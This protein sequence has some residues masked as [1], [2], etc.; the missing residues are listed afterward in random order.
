MLSNYTHHSGFCQ[1]YLSNLSATK[2]DPIYTTYAAALERSEFTLDEGYHFLFYDSTRGADFVSDKA[3]DICIAFKKKSKYV[4][5]LK[6]LYREPVISHSYPDM[7]KYCYLPFEDIEVDVAF[8]VVSSRM[9][10]MDVTVRNP[11]QQK[12]TLQMIPFLQNNYRTFN[13]VEFL[14]E[15]N[16]IFFT[17][18]EFPDSWTVGHGVPYVDRVQ[19]ILL[20]SQS[21]ARMASY[22]SYEWGGVEIPHQVDLQKKSV[23]QVW[24]RVTHSDGNRCGHRPPKTKLTTILNGDRSRILTET[25]PGWGSGNQNI[26]GNGWYGIELGNF[27]GLGKEDRYEI[28]FVCQETGERGVISGAVAEADTNDNIRKDL[29]LA[30]SR[31]LPSST[32]LKRDIWGSGREIRLYWQ[33]AG[34]EVTYNVYRRDYRQEGTY[35]LLA[36]N[37]SKN[38][39]TDK[40]ISGDKIY[41]YVV[42]AVDAEGTMSMFSGEVN[43]IAGSDFLTGVKY[44]GQN[45]NAVKDLARV[46]AAPLDLSI[47]PGDSTRFRII[48][49]V[50]P[51]GGD[52]RKLLSD[53]RKLL[54]EPLD[55]YIKAN[56]KLYRSV[57]SL[58]FGDPDR[59]ML[60]WCAFSLI[61]Q[62]ML[63]PEGKCGYN[64]YVFSREPAWGWGHG[65]Q[66]FHESLT[67]L[68]Y[69]FM[70]PQSAMNSQRVYRERQHQE[71]YI[72]YRTGPF[73]DETIPRNDQLTTSAPWYA[74]QNWEIYRITKDR[75]FLKEMY[76]SSKKFYEYV[77]ANRDSD[78]DG[79]CEWGAHAVLESVRD[80]MVAVW[81]DVGWPSNFAALDMNTMLTQEAKAL[82]AMA[83]ELDLESDASEWGKEAETLQEKI[84]QTFWDEETGFYYHV[85]KN[86]HSFTF[87]NPADLKREEII[88]FL[89]LWAGIAPQDRA[90]KLLEKLTDPGK[91]WRKYGIP[92]LAADDPYYNPGGYWNGPVWV[93]WNYLIERGLL[94]YGYN[95]LAKELVNRVAANMI[96]QLKKNHQ[97]WELYSP[98]EQWAGHNRQ[99]IWA[100][101]IARMMIDVM[102]AP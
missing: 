24:G 12:A 16:A 36:G 38:F 54:E 83:R 59:E 102:P 35:N 57:P 27:G 86:N 33:P 90:K 95:D 66:V 87:K 53:A 85:N 1:V 48:R 62:C 30:E 23:H 63:P 73:L 29:S 45:V 101:I 52:R 64:Y 40:N 3:G 7:V 17:H 72:N 55:S 22:R 41:G 51:A 10:L 68:A 76:E 19:N 14:P 70:D 8:L 26:S 67:M 97:L 99:Y 88:G 47:E 39:Y 15:K 56:E 98:D 100:G 37:L 71:G 74:W 13:E 44:P 58:K 25:A 81:R 93:Q 79:L 50:A 4:Y 34:D 82:S 61:R 92:T 80:G 21:P 96:A 43:N 32:G 94:Q 5:V 42:T 69:A 9:A 77:I 84:N 78:G 75:E 89:P 28:L 65:G 46:I 6:D 18:E 31:P 49:A 11:G 20:L 91:F 60:Y 2:D